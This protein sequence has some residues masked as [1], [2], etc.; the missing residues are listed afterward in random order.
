MTA[1]YWTKRLF[2]VEMFLEMF[3]NIVKNHLPSE[4]QEEIMDLWDDYC[5]EINNIKTGEEDEFNC[6]GDKVEDSLG[7]TGGLNDG[8]GDT[9]NDQGC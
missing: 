2:I 3:V 4:T 1:D 7:C 9:P 5:D 6:M 8:D